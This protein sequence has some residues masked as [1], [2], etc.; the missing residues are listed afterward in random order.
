MS[1]FT[2]SDSDDDVCE[3]KQCI[4]SKCKKAGT[5]HYHKRK[6]FV[7]PDQ[8]ST[9]DEWL[10]REGPQRNKLTDDEVDSLKHPLKYP[11]RWTYK[12]KGL[13]RVK[14]YS[15]CTAPY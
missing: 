1:F 14:R 15:Q 5:K 11:R 10:R 8:V 3:W 9:L 4:D 13:G 12:T 6:L 7:C 2:A